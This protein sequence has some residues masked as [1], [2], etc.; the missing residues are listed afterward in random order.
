MPL[1]SSWR[2]HMHLSSLLLG[3]YLLFL[4]RH[5]KTTRNPSLFMCHEVCSQKAVHK[6]ARAEIHHSDAVCRTSHARRL[7]GEHSLGVNL[8]KHHHVLQKLGAWQTRAHERTLGTHRCSTKEDMAP[9]S[10][11]NLWGNFTNSYPRIVGHQSRSEVAAC[12][13]LAKERR[14]I[15]TECDFLHRCPSP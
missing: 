12:R 1:C 2:H 4:R 8:V 7:P 15:M 3:L 13:L 5:H 6:D 11:S 14:L 9:W 10:T